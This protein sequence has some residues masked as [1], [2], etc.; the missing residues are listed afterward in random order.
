[1]NHARVETCLRRK[2]QQCY[3][4]CWRSWKEKHLSGMLEVLEGEDSS[5]QLKVMT[6][7]S[8]NYEVGVAQYDRRS[9]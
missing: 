3:L 8:E 9:I 7:T 2:T 5:K 1:M 4:E 6:L